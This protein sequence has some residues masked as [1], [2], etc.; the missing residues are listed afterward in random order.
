MVE[1]SLI[2]VAF[3]LGAAGSCLGEPSAPATE[4]NSGSEVL[5]QCER[6]LRATQKDLTLSNLDTFKA[7][8][9]FGTVSTLLRWGPLLSEPYRFCAPTVTIPQ[10]TQV[11]LQFLNENPEKTAH[12]PLE[13]S[14]IVAFQRAWPCK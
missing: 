14:A 8:S 7:G 10:A 12:G 11:L 9:C 1:K 6:M 3:L 5:Q 13:G 2:T 4:Q